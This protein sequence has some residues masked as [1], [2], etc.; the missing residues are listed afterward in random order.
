MKH[1]FLLFALL[2]VS[3]I[4]YSQRVYFA[5]STNIW[6]TVFVYNAGG[7]G[8]SISN[9]TSYKYLDS[10]V[11][12]NGKNYKV[13]SRNGVPITLVREDTILQKVFLKPLDTL[14]SD[15]LKVQ[16]TEEFVYFDYSMH[17]NDTLNIPLTYTGAP[18]ITDTFQV[19][20][21]VVQSVDS[22]LINNIW[23]KVLTMNV[24]S[25]FKYGGGY[26]IIQGIG[27]NFT[28]P[29]IEP[30]HPPGGIYYIDC[31]QNQGSFPIDSLNQCSST[32]I[33]N[34]INYKS[35]FK[36]FP[37]PA[38]EYIL[39]VSNYSMDKDSEWLLSDCFGRILKKETYNG[40]SKISVSD[41]SNGIY[42]LQINSRYGKTSCFK[43]VVI[44]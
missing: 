19:S 37:N 24:A 11:N 15:Y 39:I 2:I 14:L 3:S 12:Y 44:H 35:N 16:T 42:Y 6:G 17:I 32:D 1:S 31:F 29:I 34:D 36:V 28:G 5:D 7:A 13:L 38:S 9:H 25:G 10:N 26:K 8:N 30:S 18:W 33:P 22:V 20:K 23:H 40:Q 27:S 4:T 43:I 41:L 21:H